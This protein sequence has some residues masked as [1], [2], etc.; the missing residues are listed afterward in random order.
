MLFN[1]II[2][3]TE[4]LSSNF[5][6]VYAIL[7]F[8]NL[9]LPFIIINYFIFITFINMFINNGTTAI[10]LNFFSKSRFFFSKKLFYI[11]L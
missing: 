4:S 2:S 11:K 3:T 8:Y 10:K 9:F 5:N 7:D 1:Y 6:N